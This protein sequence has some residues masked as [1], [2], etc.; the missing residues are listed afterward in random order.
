MQLDT[1][2]ELERDPDFY[3][4]DIHCAI[5]DMSEK[6]TREQLIMAL[7]EVCGPL[8]IEVIDYAVRT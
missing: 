3:A 1:N 7:A 5:L 2:A 6:F 4:Q 8:K